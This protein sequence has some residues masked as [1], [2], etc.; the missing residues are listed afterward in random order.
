MAH[1][2]V[3]NSKLIQGIDFGEQSEVNRLIADP[4]NHCVVLYPGPAAS[5][6]GMHR[7]SLGEKNLVVF[8]IDG[9]WSCAG[10][11]LRRSA[12]LA[13]L[14]QICFTPEHKSE[15]QIRVQPE[16]HCLSTL[17]AVHRVLELLDPS[18]N[19]GN[20]LDVFRGMVAMQLRYAQLNRIRKVT[21]RSSSL[22]KAPSPRLSQS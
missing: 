4:E 1:L 19:P 2:C 6:I 9:T 11:M 18:L 20:M 17:E 10:K 12:N 5:D 13:R 8:V 7:G 22:P 3:E 16:A 15:Y 14:P 21:E